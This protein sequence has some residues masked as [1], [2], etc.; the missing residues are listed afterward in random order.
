MLNQCLQKGVNLRGQ[1]TKLVKNC[2]SGKIINVFGKIVN[3]LLKISAS[4]HCGSIE[5][6]IYPNLLTVGLPHSTCLS[7]RAFGTY[8]C[9]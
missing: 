2:Q 8:T 4:F 3:L 7:E 6:I 1:V 5:N 9:G